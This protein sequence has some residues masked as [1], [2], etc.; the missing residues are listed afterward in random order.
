MSIM[1]INKMPQMQLPYH[2]L[3][4]HC[5]MQPAV[6]SFTVAIKGLMDHQQ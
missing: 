5:K 6:L 3:L 1:E 4:R 2:S